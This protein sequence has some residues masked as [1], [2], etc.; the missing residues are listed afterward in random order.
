MLGCETRQLDAVRTPVHPPPRQGRITRKTTACGKLSCRAMPDRAETKPLHWQLI[1][2]NISNSTHHPPSA[3]R[4]RN[5]SL[6]AAVGWRMAGRALPLAVSKQHCRNGTSGFGAPRSAPH[7][8]RLDVPRTIVLG[9]FLGLHLLLKV[10]QALEQHLLIQQRALPLCLAVLQRLLQ[11]GDLWRR[12]KRCPHVRRVPQLP[13]EGRRGHCGDPQP[14]SPRRT[15]SCSR[16]M[17]NCIFSTSAPRS[18]AC[19]C[20]SVISFRDFSLN[21]SSCDFSTAS[22]LCDSSV[23]CSSCG[24]AGT[25]QEPGTSLCTLS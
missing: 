4:L 13:M 5:S 22:E 18:L 15:S 7:L 23:I 16:P 14:A 10:V 21:S 6:A 11:P 12:G 25:A 8:Q 20:E 9:A 3:A 19:F 24:R 2:I 1:N 17:L